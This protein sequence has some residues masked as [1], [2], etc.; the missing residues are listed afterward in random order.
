MAQPDKAYYSPTLAAAEGGTVDMSRRLQ[1][2]GFS[3]LALSLATKD[4]NGNVHSHDASTREALDWVTAHQ[5][6]PFFLYLAYPVP[7]VSIQ[8]PGHLDDLTDADG[9]V[10][11]N[12][13]RTAVDEFYPGQPFGAPI[14]HA[15]LRST[16][17][18]RPTSA[19]NTPP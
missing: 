10:F 2:T 14:A 3:N 13:V 7:H 9:I 17:P 1:R 5:D 11:D 19:T 12:S 4:N 15:G 8:P 18:P 6:E 16:T